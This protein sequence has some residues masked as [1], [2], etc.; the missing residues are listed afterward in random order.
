MESHPP[1]LFLSFSHSSGAS[2]IHSHIF[3]PGCH[4][5]PDVPFLFI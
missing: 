3:F 4:P 1:P 5:S 2:Q